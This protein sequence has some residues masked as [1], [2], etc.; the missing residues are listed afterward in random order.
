MVP[1]GTNIRIAFH[2]AAPFSDVRKNFQLCLA[3]AGLTVV[4]G[5][6][7]TFNTP[8]D[9]SGQAATAIF[10]LAESHAVIHTYPE[11]Q[12][13]GYVEIHH[14]SHDRNEAKAIRDKVIAAM[15]LNFNPVESLEAL[16][17]NSEVAQLIRDVPYT[18]EC[19]YR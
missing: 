17:K 15:K 19:N 10:I 14:C 18:P 13:Y 4:D 11:L 16:A 8:E 5:L 12:N 1:F 3:H 6:S 2:N 9:A 7:H